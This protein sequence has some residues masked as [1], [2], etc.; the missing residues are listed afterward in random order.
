MGDIT[1]KLDYTHLLQDAEI[2]L[3]KLSPIER[4]VSTVEGNVFLMRILPY[5]TTEDRI[6]GVVVTFIDIT[7]RKASETAIAED[8][9]AT[10]ILHNLSTRLVT[11][12]N[13]QILYDEVMAAAI[14][15]THA[16]AGTVQILDEPSQ[17]LMLL[18]TNGFS[19]KMIEHFS[20]VNAN[21]N[22]PCGIALANGHRS[23]VDFDEEGPEEDESNKMHIEEG[24]LSAQSTPLIAR[25]GKPIGMIST[26]FK[27]H[28]HRP[29]ERELR[30]LD[31]LARQAADLIEQR[32]AARELQDKMEELTRF[33]NAMV[34]RES[35]MIELKKEI[36]ELCSQLGQS[37]R[38]PLDF[39]KEENNN[40]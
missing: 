18:A 14:Q 40:G 2:V 8:L 35:R 38:Y 33:N 5:R 31:L 3:D 36:N 10:Q 32:L 27:E 20:L 34:H 6:N 11:E 19:K 23:F 29:D 9:K 22:T 17:E 21:S 15:L 26:H 12:E 39:E 30:Y 24:Y 37:P 25:S 1:N 16:D 7:E 13:F 28:H 4:E